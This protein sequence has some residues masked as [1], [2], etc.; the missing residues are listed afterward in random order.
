MKMDECLAFFNHENK[1]LSVGTLKEYNKDITAFKAF[2]QNKYT[3]YF[4]IRQIKEQDLNDYL[5]MLTA[6]KGYKPSSRNRQMNTLRSFL[7]FVR[8]K[9]L[10]KKSSRVSSAIKRTPR[11]AVFL[12]SKEV[13]ELIPAINHPLIQ[14]VVLTLF[15]TGLRITECLKLE[16]TDV[17]FQQN[18]ITVK[19]GKEINVESFLCIQN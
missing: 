10:L 11:Q 2:L 14:L 7:S 8:R 5:A 1:Q 3:E 13:G 6:V 4:D 17:D 12:T 19:H 18:T 9:A 16:L 15:Y